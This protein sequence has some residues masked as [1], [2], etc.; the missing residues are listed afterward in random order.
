MFHLIIEN[1]GVKR[2]IAKSDSDNFKEGMYADCSID[3]GCIPDTYVRE[4]SIRCSGNEPV[5]IKAK[6]YRD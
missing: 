1:L 3:N 4:I 5:H 6:V 2:C